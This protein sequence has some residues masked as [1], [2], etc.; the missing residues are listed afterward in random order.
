MTKNKTYNSFEEIETDLKILK[1]TKEINM[2]QL[3]NNM[4][5]LKKN[6]SVK[7]IIASSFSGTGISLLNIGKKRWL[8]LIADYLVY[9]FFTRKGRR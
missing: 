7:N 3:K 1:L 9:Y 4:T 2:L 8:S 5:D 6:L